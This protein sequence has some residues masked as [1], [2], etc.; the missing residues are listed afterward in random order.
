MYTSLS[1][2]EISFYTAIWS[3]GVFFALYNFY[4]ASQ[5]A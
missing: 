1:I 5:C 4:L 3:S 2:Y